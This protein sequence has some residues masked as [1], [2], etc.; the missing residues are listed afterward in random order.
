MRKWQECICTILSQDNKELAA[1]IQSIKVWFPILLF[2]SLPHIFTPSQHHPLIPLHD[3]MRLERQ[4][5]W[6]DINPWCDSSWSRDLW[7]QTTSC[8]PSHVQHTKAEP[9]EM[10]TDSPI[11][12]GEE[13]EA[14]SSHGLWQLWNPGRHMLPGSPTRGKGVSLDQIPLLLPGRNFPDSVWFS[15]QLCVP[16]FGRSFFAKAPP[17]LPLKT[18]LGNMPHLVAEQPTSWLKKVGRRGVHRY[19][20]ISKSQ[21]SLLVQALT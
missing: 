7:T 17:W 4:H 14:Y 6:I 5:L 19:F 11:L 21:K 16:L 9:N 13:W 20:Y 8:F 2:T 3:G 12:I 1:I 18:A 10:T 15:L